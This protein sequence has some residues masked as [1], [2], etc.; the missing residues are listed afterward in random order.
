MHEKWCVVAAGSHFVCDHTHKPTAH[1]REEGLEE[2]VKIVF[3]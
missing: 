3:L 1:A 2:N